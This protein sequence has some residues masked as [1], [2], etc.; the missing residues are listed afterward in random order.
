MGKEP[1]INPAISVVIPTLDRNHLLSRCLDRLMPELGPDDEVVVVDSASTT[2]DVRAVAESRGARYIR[3]DIRGTSLARNI[4][5]RS[6][7]NPIIGFIDDDVL[8]ESGWAERLRAELSDGTTQ[9]VIGSV[10]PDD[11]QRAGVRTILVD[12]NPV[13]IGRSTP[14]SMGLG[15]NGGALRSALESIG[16]YDE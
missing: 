14:G 2:D 9:F 1:Q 16:G 13:D 11:E 12:P 7:G 6:S 8:V 3:S 4:G 10:H 5:W 15:C